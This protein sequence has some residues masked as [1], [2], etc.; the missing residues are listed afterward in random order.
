[1][2]LQ[3]AKQLLTA[4]AVALAIHAHA[5][6][7]TVIDDGAST[8]ISAPSDDIEVR[9]AVGPVA[10]TVNIE[11][12]AQ[13]GFV[14]NMD[15][16][17]MM[18]PVL[19]PDT[20]LPVE[21]PDTGEVVMEPVISNTDQSVAVFGTSSVNM[22][23]GETA[24]SFVGNENSVSA[25]SGGVI[26]DDILLNDSAVINLSGGAA[27][28]VVI[29]GSSTLNMSGGSVDTV[30]ISGGTFN[31]SGGR[32]DDIENATGGEVNISGDAHVDDDAFFFGSTVV[33]VTGGVFDDEFQLF[34]NVTATFS[35]GSIDDDLVVAGN[36]QAVI[37]DLSVGDAIEASG[38]STTTINGGDFGAIEA[39]EG[40]VVNMTAGSVSE[41]LL[42]ALG[43]T[44]NVT[45]GSLGE[46]IS[47]SLNG[48]VNATV[49][50]VASELTI[51]AG[52]NGQVN[53]SGNFDADLIEAST[54]AGS[55]S[56]NGGRAD[57]LSVLAELGGQIAVTDGD[58][59][60]VTIEAIDDSN[61]V[62]RGGLVDSSVVLETRS[63][64]TIFGGFYTYN[65]IPVED[66]NTVFGPG[67]FDPVTGEIFLIA[68]DITGILV[69]GTKFTMTYSRQFNAG[70]NSRVFLKIPEPSTA[71]LGLLAVGAV[72]GIRRAS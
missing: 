28:D 19:D 39:I 25:I 44:V 32:I 55:I 70:S 65:G 48:V 13:V 46:E 15:G 5:V 2:S 10:T 51:E 68:G 35:G 23:D 47:A 20:G 69:D 12:G 29:T 24:D 27:D 34:E 50:S 45:G 49:S 67:A 3:Q 57:T 72:V 42:A 63:R 1:M 26:G 71:L 38:S 9:D 62:V 52:A 31:F 16:T 30:E 58:Y 37:N 17:I 59:H 21:D 4:C 22:S 18:T 7:T 14:L 8:S 64:M 60:N 11:A 41:T 36:A 66:L 43:S 54:L 61:V 33:H 40:A 56:L 6:A 53:L